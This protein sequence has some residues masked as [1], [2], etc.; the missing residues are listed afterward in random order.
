[1]PKARKRKVPVSSIET[2]N[3]SSNTSQSSRTII[4]Q[5][6]VLLKRQA[7]LKNVASDPSTSTALADVE[8]QIEELGGLESYQRMSAAGQGNDRGGGSE[9]VLIGWLKDMEVHKNISTKLRYTLFIS[10]QPN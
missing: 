8:Q 7:Q 3:S 5:F 1:M 6:H 10:R 9:K 2:A 4:R